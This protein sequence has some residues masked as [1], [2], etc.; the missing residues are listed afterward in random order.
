[1]N[2]HSLLT[3][4]VNAFD[5][6]IDPNSSFKTCFEVFIHPKSLDIPEITSTAKKILQAQEVSFVEIS[7]DEYQV[8]KLEEN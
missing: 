3:E 1:M 8:C 6:D 7:V 4:I 2:E 5:E